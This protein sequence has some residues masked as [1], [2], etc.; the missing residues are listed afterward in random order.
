MVLL[1]VTRYLKL[2]YYGV[3]TCYTVLKT[4]LLWCCYVLYGIYNYV[5][6]ALLQVILCL[7][8]RY[9]GVV[10]CYTVFKITLLWC[11]YVLYGI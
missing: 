7:K 9:Y 3:V 8:L 10:T 2:R 5:T 11:C 1:H 4:T 6:I